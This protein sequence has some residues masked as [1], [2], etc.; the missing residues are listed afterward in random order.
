MGL[1][2]LDFFSG[3]LTAESSIAMW[4]APKALHDVAMLLRVVECVRITE[5]CEQFERSSLQLPAL[6]VLKR[7]VEKDALITIKLQVEADDDCLLRNGECCRIAGECTRRAAEQI[8]R[9]LIQ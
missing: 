5:A 1:E 4:E 8:A 6:A 2:K 9:K 7:H 3:R